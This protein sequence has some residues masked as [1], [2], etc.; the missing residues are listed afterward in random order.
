MIIIGRKYGR[1][2][3]RLYLFAY[4]IACARETGTTVVN[5]A[6]CEYAE[7]FRGTSRDR[8]CRYPTQETG[9]TSR[10]RRELSYLA[11]YLPARALIA[12]RAKRW[13][14]R[15]IRLRGEEIFNLEAPDFRKLLGEPTPVVL[16]GWNFRD[17]GAFYRH[18][19]VIREH[20]RPVQEREESV[21]GVLSRARQQGDVVVGVH[22]RQDD[23][24]R[25]R[26]GQYFYTVPQYAQLM[27]QV[28]QEL[29]PR[30]CVFLVCSDVPQRQSDFPGI[31]V[32]FGAGHP[33]DDLYSFAG[34][35]YLMGPPSTY[36]MWASFYGRVPLLTLER[37]D[38][39]PQL[40]SFTPQCF[41]LRQRAA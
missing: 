13:P 22:V 4:I 27:R 17:Q 12:L 16:Q 25:F 33:V 6:F 2:A 26:N 18:T 1:L 29:R 19:D 5:P 38:V 30:T 40:E 36:S 41:E 15:I 23:Y 35:D 10:W 39:R 34:C 8:L 21:A 14:W 31:R 11:T 37:P 9:P 24:A 20:F 7:F 28:Q 3:N 32:L